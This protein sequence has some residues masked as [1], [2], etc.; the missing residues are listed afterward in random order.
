MQMN[1]FSALRA[2]RAALTAMVNN[3]GGGAIVNVASVNAFFQPDG[4]TIDYGA[5]RAALVNLTKSLSQEFGARG[6]R[7]QTPSRLAREH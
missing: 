6:I 2:T 3:G 4:G 7:R 5:A 1:F